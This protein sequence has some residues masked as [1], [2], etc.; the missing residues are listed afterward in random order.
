MNNLK[1]S[2]ENFH[3]KAFANSWIAINP[4]PKGVI[5]FVGSFFVF[6][7]LPTL[8]YNS[9]LRSLYDQGYTIIAYPIAVIPPLIWKSRL[10]DHWQASIQLLKEEY[11]IKLELIAYILEHTNGEYLDIYLDHANYF[12]LGHSLGCKYISILEILS[13]DPSTIRDRL[14]ECGFKPD[15]FQ[16]V[17]EDI[18]IIESERIKS[19]REINNLLARK[20]VAQNVSSRQSII[21]QP[22]IFLAPEIYGTQDSSGATIP[23]FKVFPSG[24]QTL[25]LIQKSRNFFNLTSLISFEGDEISEDDVQNLKQELSKRNINQPDKL[26]C[27]QFPGCNLKLKFIS[28]L[29]SH[30]KP[31]SNSIEPLANCIDKIFQE[32]RQRPISNY[33]PQQ[34]QCENSNN[35]QDG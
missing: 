3:F 21:D 18:S 22:S 15:D 23:W 30:L 1:N 35:C 31:A 29:F 10:V 16:L 7:S 28:S 27:K 9:L 8:F 25:C 20:E 11:T 34:V 14:E 6:G 12:W 26:L 24:E 33:I 19:D 32:L 2:V 5:Q 4:H 17:E 13:S